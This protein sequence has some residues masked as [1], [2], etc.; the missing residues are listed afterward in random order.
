MIR[1]TPIASLSELAKKKIIAK[2]RSRLTAQ[3]DRA[4]MTA[5]NN[6]FR[7]RLARKTP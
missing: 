6:A 5:E 4:L 2:L 1:P 3:R 7:K